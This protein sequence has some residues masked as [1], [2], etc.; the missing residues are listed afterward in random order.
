MGVRL[1]PPA[2]RP[3][4]PYTKERQKVRCSSNSENLFVIEL[5]LLLVIDIM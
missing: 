2:V 4:D 1:N 3:D 5:P